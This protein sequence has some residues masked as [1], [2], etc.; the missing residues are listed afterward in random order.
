ME[1]VLDPAPQHKMDSVGDI[2]KAQELYIEKTL[3]FVIYHKIVG[4]DT[5]HGLLA[6]SGRSNEDTGQFP[7]VGWRGRQTPW[8]SSAQPQC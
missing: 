8:E 3:G 7:K 4:E 6:H 2:F 1:Q 5:T